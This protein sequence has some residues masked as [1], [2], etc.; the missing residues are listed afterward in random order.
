M[1]QLDREKF[2]HFSESAVLEI[3]DLSGWKGVL[4]QNLTDSQL[5]CVSDQL[6]AILLGEG[7]KGPDGKANAAI[8]MALLL[9][10]RGR[11]SE[12]FDDEG[13]LLERDLEVLREM[14]ML[15]SVAAD[16]E[17]VGRLLNRPSDSEDLSLLAG[18]EAM[19]ANEDARRAVA[20]QQARHHPRAAA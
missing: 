1:L 18:I 19:I 11:Q 20:S 2:G 8:T 7:S 6:R 3:L 10:A 12:L 16:R 17:L 13:L 9:L 14:L 15:L 4:P 5:V